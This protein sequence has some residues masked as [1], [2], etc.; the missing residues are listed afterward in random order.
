MEVVNM[1]DIIKKRTATGFNFKI[2][3]EQG[4][5]V[6]SFEGNLDL[7]WTYI[8]DDLLMK[9]NYKEFIITKE[10]YYLYTLFEELYNDIKKYN[11]YQLDENDLPFCESPEEIEQK[12]KN[13]KKMNNYL[14]KKE[15]YNPESLIRNNSVEWHSDDCVYENS[16]VLKIKK[17]KETFIVIF[18]KSKV[19]DPFFTS[20]VRISNSGSRYDPFNLV[21]MKMYNDLILYD[22]EY[23]Q[24]HIEEYLYQKKLIKK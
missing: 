8:V 22:S 19:E 21:F 6:I 1:E 10:N 14:R 5:F 9:P 16:S 13:F 11:V 18:E 20:S 4:T 24:I 12:V 7:H 3:T 15:K 23:H 17:K 2:T